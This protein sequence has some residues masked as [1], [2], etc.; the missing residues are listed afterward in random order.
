MPRV[1]QIRGL[2]NVDLVELPF[3]PKRANSRSSPS[4]DANKASTK[5]MN[6]CASRSVS[7]YRPFDIQLSMSEMAAALL[8]SNEDKILIDHHKFV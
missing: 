8:S 2:L 7:K 5:T 1:Y 3:V 6:L 4:I